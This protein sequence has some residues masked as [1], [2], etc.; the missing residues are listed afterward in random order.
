MILDALTQNFKGSEIGPLKRDCLMLLWPAI[1]VTNP[2]QC[3]LSSD[4]LAGPLLN[5]LIIERY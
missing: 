4:S 5:I 2:S 3:L 1:Q